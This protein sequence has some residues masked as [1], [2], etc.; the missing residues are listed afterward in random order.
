MALLLN[1]A[2]NLIVIPRW[3]YD[4]AAAMTSVTELLLAAAMTTFAIRATGRI[5][6]PRILV[7]PVLACGAIGLVALVAGTG[8][9][10]L[11]LCIATYP[12]ALLA[13]ERRLFPEDLRLV[14]GL[15]ASGGAADQGAPRTS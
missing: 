14:R 15:L 4:G 7:G 11:G 9:F 8:L 10:G 1:V 2:G 13:V 3:S 6:A 5:S 12:L